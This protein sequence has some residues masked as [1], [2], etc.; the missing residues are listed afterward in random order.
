MTLSYPQGAWNILASQAGVVRGA[1]RAVAVRHSAVEWSAVQAGSSGFSTLLC[2]IK[3]GRYG[4][5]WCVRR[6]A[7]SCRAVQLLL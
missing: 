3:C 1:D 7:L 2:V 5:S 4:P 6:A